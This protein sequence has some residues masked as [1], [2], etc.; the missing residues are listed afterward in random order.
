[1]PEMVLISAT[2]SVV[3]CSPSRTLMEEVLLP[4]STVGCGQNVSVRDDGAATEGHSAR[5]AD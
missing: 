3:S 4:G 2:E 1:M 5:G